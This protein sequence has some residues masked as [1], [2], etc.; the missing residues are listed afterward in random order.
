MLAQ[1]TPSDRHGAAQGALATSRTAATALAAAGCGALFGVAKILPF[2]GVALCLMLLGV[3]AL[4][5]WRGLPARAL[6]ASGAI[7]GPLQ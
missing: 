4:V 6:E 5:V 7:E 1:W 2:A 3:V